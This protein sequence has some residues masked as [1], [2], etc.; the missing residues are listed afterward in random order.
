MTGYLIQKQ[1]H[2]HYL[3]CT[4]VDWADVFSRKCYK[5]I[6]IDSLAYCQKEKGLIVYAYVIMSNHI[7]LIAA[8]KE[9]SKGLSAIIGNFKRHTAKQ[10]LKTIESQQES[11][12][13]W[14]LNLFAYHARFNRNNQNYQVWIQDNH[15]FETA[16]DKLKT[17]G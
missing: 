6:I 4:I 15:P 12:R 13:E 9:K 17:T 14:L 7:H 3:T 10:I 8:A 11:R 1:Y 2:I 5:A 16:I